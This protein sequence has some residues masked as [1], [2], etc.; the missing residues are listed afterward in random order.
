MSGDLPDNVTL[1][2]LGRTAIAVRDDV[3][4]L[5]DDLDRLIVITRRLDEQ[6]IVTGAALVRIER[7]LDRL[8]GERTGL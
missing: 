4:S 6:A 1:E 8:E 7:R 3:R 5:R 2:W